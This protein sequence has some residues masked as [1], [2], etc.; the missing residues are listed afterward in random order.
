M[1]VKVLE[2]IASGVPVVTTPA[3][4]EGIAPS[5]GVVVETEPRAL[6]STA[7][8][9][10]RDDQARRERGAAARKTFEEHYSPG[11]A[12]EPLVELYRRLAA[13]RA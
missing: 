2:A 9:L 3:G 1:K 6:A 5:D 4:A 8:E 7:A 10:L 11:P 13:A 12:T